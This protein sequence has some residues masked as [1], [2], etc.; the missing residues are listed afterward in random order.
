MKEEKETFIPAFFSGWLTPLYDLGCAFCGLGERYRQ[1]VKNKLPLTNKNQ[2]ILDVGCG[3]GA[4]LIDLKKT[5]PLGQFY[6]IDED[7]KINVS[8]AFAQHL[9]FQKNSFDIIYSSLVFHHLPS[10]VKKAALQ[11][12]HRVLKQDGIFILIDFGQPKRPFLSFPWYALKFEEGYDNYHGNIPKMIKTAKFHSVR[13][14]G[15]YK[16]DIYIWKA[17]K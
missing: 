3:T 17:K 15:N 13:K 2:K 11:E 6:G 4:I 8:S 14:I 10:L 9:P 16:H 5:H 1:F 7:V 12:I